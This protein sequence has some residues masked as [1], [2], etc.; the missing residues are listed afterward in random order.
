MDIKKISSDSKINL[1]E[2]FDSELQY[3]WCDCDCGVTAPKKDKATIKELKG[4][5][6]IYKKHICNPTKDN[7][8]E[9]EA[10]AEVYG[11]GTYCYCTGTKKTLG[12]W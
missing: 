5:Y 11:N 2:Q 1:E 9:G 10:R 6:N 4:T 7:Q 8:T 3:F 12:W